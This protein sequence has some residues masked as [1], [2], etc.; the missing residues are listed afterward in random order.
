MDFVGNG[1]IDLEQNISMADRSA[2]RTL[3]PT[4]T[5][6]THGKIPAESEVGPLLRPQGPTGSTVLEEPHAMEPARDAL[7]PRES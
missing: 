3:E 1:N 5:H 7:S 6:C 2:A 4:T